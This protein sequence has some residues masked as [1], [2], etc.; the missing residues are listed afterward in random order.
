[1][2]VE[3]RLG[4]VLAEDD[5]HQGCHICNRNDIIVIDVAE[6]D[7]DRY[8]LVELDGLLIG[9]ACRLVVAEA[10]VVVVIAQISSSRTSNVYFS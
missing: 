6:N 1:M 2:V 10:F 3:V 5:V 4:V 7:G 8:A 9:V